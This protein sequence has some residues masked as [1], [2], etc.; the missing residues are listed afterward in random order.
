MITICIT[1]RRGWWIEHDGVLILNAPGQGSGLLRPV[2]AAYR[3]AG[4]A[5][6][7]RR[8]RIGGR[9]EQQ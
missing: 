3:R 8:V 9:H 7:F 4:I 6:R 2:L 1:K 5:Y